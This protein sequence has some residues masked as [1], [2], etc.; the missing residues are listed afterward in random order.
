MKFQK[1]NCLMICSCWLIYLTCCMTR[2]KF[3]LDLSLIAYIFRRQQ[4]R[5]KPAR[6]WTR[7]T[8]LLAVSV[9]LSSVGR[10]LKTGFS[11]LCVEIGITSPVV[12]MTKP[13][14]ISV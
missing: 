4:S 2:F 10:H 3:G 8:R 14:A 1:K 7:K 5:R 12:Q 11:V 6:S 9:A 13:F